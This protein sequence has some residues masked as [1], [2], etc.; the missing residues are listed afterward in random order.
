MCKN[1]TRQKRDHRYGRRRQRKEDSKIKKA[2]NQ[3]GYP[4]WAINKVKNQMEDKTKSKK[5][6][7]DS[8]NNKSRGMVVIPYVQGVSE[9]LQRVF[10]NI[11]S[12]QR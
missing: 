1:V 10:K 8:D 6:T 7:K 5:K 4:D 3:C 11:T 9:R 12:T 2:L